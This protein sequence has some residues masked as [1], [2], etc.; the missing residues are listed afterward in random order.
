MS[1]RPS[2]VLVSMPWTSLGDPSL[3]L[4]VLRAV[5]DAEGIA[6]RV[7]HL[8][9]SLL[10]HVRPATY[11][12]LANAFALNDFVFGETID[13]GVTPRQ[14]RILRAKTEEM[15]AFGL[16]DAGRFGGVDG[17]VEQ[18]LRLRAETIPA[19]LDEHAAE[20]AASEATLVGLTCMFDQ[21]VASLALAKR[22]KERAPEKLVALGGYALSSPTGEEVMRCFPFVDALCTGEGEEVIAPLARAS[23]GLVDLASVP[24]LLYRAG[25]GSVRRSPALPRFDLAKS[26][27][28]NF[29]DFFADVDEMRREHRVEVSVESLPLETSRGCW[30]GQV[31]HCVF[32]GIHDDDLKYRVRP[33]E[34][35]LASLDALR[36]RYGMRSFRFSDYILP[37]A[38]EKTLLPM[39]AAR[40]EK[41]R[42]ACEMKANSTPARFRLL[43]DAGF[44]EVQPGVESFSSDV[45]RRMDKGVTAILNVQT[46]LLGKRFGVRVHYNFL[47]GLPDDE[48]APY[49]EMLEMLPRLAHLDAPVTRV[50]VQVTRYA[51]LQVN[52]ARFGIPEAEYDPSYEVVFSE[53]FLAR[54]GFDLNRYCYYFERPF[55]N[56]PALEAVYRRLVDEIDRWNQVRA[57]REVALWYEESETGLRVFD[58]RADAEGREFLLYGDDALVYPWCAAAPITVEQ[59]AEG[60][61]DQLP[62]E[63]V[64][65]AVER[66]DAEALLFRDG[67]SVIGL[68]LPR[69][70]CL[71]EHAEAEELAA[72]G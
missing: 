40:E 3:G 56:P 65:A 5:L 32:C 37:F 51:P 22:V 72:I 6:C 39:L 47:Y 18:L 54:T 34:H 38:Y 53:G 50:E 24:G 4:A 52:P 28:P 69:E 62:P 8:N 15:L 59:L 21:T 66:L 25:D 12:A 11:T 19:W 61:A 33:A 23:A 68:A 49:Q 9:L 71:P 45:L 10:R 57:E 35:V 26:P 58:S 16:I 27:T 64:R 48:L 46:L 60:L 55:Q 13:P 36:A 63:R 42:L 7:R 41:F 20:I 43:A 44:R 17:V 1:Q 70:C 2:A 30:W 31:K 29:D 67:R 14:L